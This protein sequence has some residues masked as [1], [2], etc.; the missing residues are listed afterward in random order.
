MLG[1]GRLG[2][3]DC[4]RAR[5]VGAELPTGERYGF[6][7]PLSGRAARLYPGSRLASN[8]ACR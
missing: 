2:R 6:A 7:P 1:G 5:A 8:A 3:K 4:R